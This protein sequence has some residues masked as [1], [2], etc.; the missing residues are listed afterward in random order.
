MVSLGGAP[1]KYN[2]YSSYQEVVVSDNEGVASVVPHGSACGHSRDWTILFLRYLFV[3]ALFRVSPD[4][5]APST[6]ATPSL[7]SFLLYLPFTLSFCGSLFLMNYRQQRNL[8]LSSNIGQRTPP[9]VHVFCPLSS[10]LVKVSASTHITLVC[11]SGVPSGFFFHPR[12][13]HRVCWFRQARPYLR[14]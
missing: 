11:R 2:T 10:L 4:P 7:S 6:D 8:G 1:P 12:H 13:P 14:S 3:Q 5:I 9:P